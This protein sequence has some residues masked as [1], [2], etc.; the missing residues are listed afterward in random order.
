[1]P[2]LDRTGKRA[3]FTQ[4]RV[5]EIGYRR[6]LRG[7]AHQVGLIVRGISP[8]GRV[9]DT[10]RLAATLKAYAELITPWAQ[11]VAQFMLAD[12]WRRDKAMWFRQSAEMSR[13]MRREIE[14]APTGA[15]L[16]QLQNSQVELI[17]SIPLS[18]AQHVHEYAVQAQIASI[19]HEDLARKLIELE[20][21]SK[22][23]ADLIARTE[24]SR[25][26][27]NLVQARAQYAG[28]DGYIWR[29]SGDGN[30]RPSHVAMDGKYVRWS[31]PPKTDKNLDP[32]HAGCGP[33]C[34]CYAEP[35]FPGF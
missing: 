35:V 11:S 19:R 15:M 3:A 13:H 30:V 23:K 32:Y 25:A 12:V 21:V 7:I 10:P 1:M 20:G 18:A 22:A 34:R 31:H 5:A 2:R 33:N 16:R 9:E 14:Q 29:T 26:A 24:T 4:A 28:S 8:E 27:A 6:Q 17:K